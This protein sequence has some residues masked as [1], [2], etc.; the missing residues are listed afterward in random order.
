M[1]FFSV[2]FTS[3]ISVMPAA[4]ATSTT[5]CTTGLS[6]TVI[7]SLGMALLAGRKRVPR[8]ATGR[9]AFLIMECD[10]TRA[11]GQRTSN[12]GLLL[13]PEPGR[14]GC[15]HQSPHLVSMRP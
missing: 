15:G 6:T 2:W 4:T 8:P 9:T 11:D 13:Q 10:L 14:K 12:P 3:T 7:I 5:Y 1:D